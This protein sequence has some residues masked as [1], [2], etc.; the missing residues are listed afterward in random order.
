MYVAVLSKLINK[1]HKYEVRIFELDEGSLTPIDNIKF[2][3]SGYG[4]YTTGTTDY[5]KNN[6][7]SRHKSREDWTESG[8]FTAGFWSRW[9]LWNKKTIKESIK[10]INERFYNIRVFL[11]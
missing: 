5:Q 3:A 8:Y 4:D 6:Y 10:D 2:G 7:I 9:I 11:E 1:K